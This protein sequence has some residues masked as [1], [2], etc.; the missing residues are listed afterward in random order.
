MPPPPV[1]AQPVPALTNPPAA[2]TGSTNAPG[3]HRWF[4][5]AKGGDKGT[6]WIQRKS[7]A[8]LRGK[9]Y[10]MQNRKLEFESDELNDLKIAWKDVHQVIVPR[11]LVSY[12]ERES[13]WG[14][15]RE[16]REKVTVTGV[17]A[18]AMH[19]F[20]TTSAEQVLELGKVAA[21]VER[22]KPAANH[23]HSR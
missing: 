7:G 20:A 8:W 3:K 5:R 14:S 21:L 2:T 17:I 11:A 23:Q 6:D 9:L 18:R 1:A 22:N 4:W 13:A 16:D 12:G 15:V 19:L 10:G